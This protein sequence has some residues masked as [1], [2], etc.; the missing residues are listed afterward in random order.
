M[1]FVGLFHDHLC[2]GTGESWQA[3][4][5][6]RGTGHLD[7][8]ICSTSKHRPPH[9]RG[10]VPAIPVC[11]ALSPQSTAPAEAKIRRL[12]Q[13]ETAATLPTLRQTRKLFAHGGKSL[14]RGTQPRFTPRSHSRFGIRSE[15]GHQNVRP[16]NSER[17]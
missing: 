6:E 13:A 17:I 14:T 15:L 3:L 8:K 2:Q 1:T 11:S 5:V 16:L 12:K 10:R 4:S 9:R 7:V